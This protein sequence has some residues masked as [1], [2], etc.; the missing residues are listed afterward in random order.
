[1]ASLDE[2]QVAWTYTD[3]D[4]GT[5]RKGAKKTLVDQQNVGLVAKVGGSAAAATVAPLPSYIKPRVRYVVSAAG[6]RRAVICYDTTCDLWATPGTT[7]ELE[8]GGATV[9]FTRSHSKRS[10]K[11][12]DKTTQST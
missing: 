11:Y 1:M 5:W 10:E 12:R 3:D 4:G 9:A 2:N 8:T 7:I 6:V